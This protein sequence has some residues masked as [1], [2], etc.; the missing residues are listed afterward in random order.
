M[1]TASHQEVKA[2]FSEFLARVEA[3]ETVVISRRGVPVAELR[4]VQ[5]P[6]VNERPIGLAVGEFEVPNSFFE[7][8][9]PE[10]A[11]AFEGSDG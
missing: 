4:A 3:G 5:E 9:P 6:R 2:R 7:P 8:V 10:V 11:D 1:I